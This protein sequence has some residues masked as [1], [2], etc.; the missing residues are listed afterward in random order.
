[1]AERTY[2]YDR[3]SELRFW[4]PDK[5]YNTSHCALRYCHHLVSPGFTHRPVYTG[6]GIGKKRKQPDRRR[7]RV[8]K[9]EKKER[10][11]GG[12]TNARLTIFQPE[13][14]PCAF[15]GHVRRVCR[16]PCSPERTP[17]LPRLPGR[18][19]NDRENTNYHWK[20]NITQANYASDPRIRLFD[21]TPVESTHLIPTANCL[22]MLPGSNLCF[23]PTGWSVRCIQ[24]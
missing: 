13:R 4:F 8:N 22:M 21:Q 9:R 1:M 12:R 19:R 10:E 2:R 5:S 7:R 16:R 3:E 14:R 20:V 6:A 23:I 17:L 18:Q 15:G 11:R 24:E